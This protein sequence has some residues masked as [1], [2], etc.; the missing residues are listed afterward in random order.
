MTLNDLYLYGKTSPTVDITFDTILDTV[1]QRLQCC[2]LMGTSDYAELHVPVPPSCFDTHGLSYQSSCLFKFRLESVYKAQTFAICIY[3][4]GALTLV[5]FL[6]DLILIREFLQD[7][8]L[9][10]IIDKISN[11]STIIEPINQSKPPKSQVQQYV[12]DYLLENTI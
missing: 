2:G 8:L 7:Q 3:I 12:I 10:K 5:C 4:L 1:H 9:E 6:I 11:F